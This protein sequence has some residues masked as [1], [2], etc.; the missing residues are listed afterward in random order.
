MR[1]TGM[2][3]VTCGALAGCATGAS[4]Q[5]EAES[6][7]A[8]LD[9]VRG[10]GAYRCAPAALARSEAELEFLLTELDQGHAQRAAEHR[11]RAGAALTQVVAG[12]QACAQDAD[13]DGV[14]L[15]DDRCPDVP[16]PVSLGG[17]PDQDNDGIVDIDDR[18]PTVPEDRDGN[19][20]EDGCPESEDR[21]G[22]GI[23]DS[24]DQCPDAPEDIDQF[25]DEDGCPDPDND[26]DGIP[27]PDDACPMQPE[28]KNGYDDEDGCPDK[29][30]ELVDVKRAAKKIEIKE[31]I[32]FRP[33]G[34]RIKSRSF[35]LLR[36][37]VTVLKTNPTMEVVIEGHTDSR[38]PARSNLR[39]SKRR[40]RSVRRFLIRRGIETKRLTAIG[41][42][43]ERPLA[44]NRTRRGRR[45]NRRIEFTITAE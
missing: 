34:A 3:V 1:R 27:D 26:A 32:F 31:R 43:E 41:Y 7:Q 9:D 14:L 45:R 33:G 20:D 25:E 28:T 19:A 8:Q 36:Q 15:G 37:V 21:D 39:L 38:G 40:A 11:D 10:A 42:G 17:C 30:L 29:K 18:C 4:L 44:S 5:R 24:A 35:R 16:G 12:V 2:L 23:V 6:I 13:G 22:D